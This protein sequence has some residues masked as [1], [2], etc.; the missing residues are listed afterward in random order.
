MILLH[1]RCGATRVVYTYN[2]ERQR[3]HRLPEKRLE[4][5]GKRLLGIQPHYLGRGTDY[6]QDWSL[7]PPR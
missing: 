7:A 6:R 1:S 2:E 5:G 4:H 3:M